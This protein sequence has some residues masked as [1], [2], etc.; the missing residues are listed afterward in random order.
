MPYHWEPTESLDY[1]NIATPIATPGETTEYTVTVSDN[2]G[3]V[4][5]AQITVQ[6]SG[7][8][9]PESSMDKIQAYPNP[10]SGILQIEGVQ[11]TANYRIFNSQGQILMRG[12]GE[13]NMQI[14]L[15]PLGQGFYFLEI[16]DSLGVS[17]R[18]IV[19]E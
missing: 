17:T 7:V 1:A 18:K 16:S 10:T 6:V 2:A 9:V 8:N 14:N 12:Q 3:N 4:G 19:V 13:G 15:K 11:G 5:T